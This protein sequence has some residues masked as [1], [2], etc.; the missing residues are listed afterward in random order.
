MPRYR[1]TYATT[2][3][4]TVDLDAADEEAAEDQSWQLAEDFLHTVH[5]AGTPVTAE[6]SL[7]GIGSDTIEETR[8]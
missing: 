3:H 6:A 7:D 5:G 2:I 8:G 4:M 1:V